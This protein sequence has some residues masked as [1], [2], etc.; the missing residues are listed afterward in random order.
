MSRRFLLHYYIDFHDEDDALFC[1]FLE[2]SEQICDQVEQFAQIEPKSNQGKLLLQPRFVCFM[3]KNHSSRTFRSMPDPQVMFYLMDTKQDPDY[4]RRF[5][6]EIAHWPWRRLH[7]E[8]PPLFQEGIAVYAELMSEPSAD[9]SDF[10]TGSS[11]D[12][13]EVPPLCD[14]ALTENFLGA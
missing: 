7:N 12:V 14:M 11:L 4:M 8:A 2:E 13:K 6:H 9:V 5:R 1:S 3:V 10:L